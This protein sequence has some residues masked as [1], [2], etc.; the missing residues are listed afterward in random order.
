MEN[1]YQK[2][3]IGNGNQKPE[4][5]KHTNRFLFSNFYNWFPISDN[6]F[7]FYITN[8]KAKKQDLI[9]QIKQILNFYFEGFG[10]VPSQL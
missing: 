7:L 5:S 6:R 10:H 8:F 3:E 4:S 9:I 2:T 1:S